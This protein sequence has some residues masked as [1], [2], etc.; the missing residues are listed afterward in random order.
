MARLDFKGKWVLVTGAS[1]GLGR[2]MAMQLAMTEGANLVLMA[3]RADRLEEVKA[4]ILQRT[5]VEVL[6]IPCDLSDVHA[7]EEKLHALLLDMPLYAAVLNAGMTYFGAHLEMGR[8]TLNAL[9][10]LNIKSVVSLTNIL[11]RYFEEH[12]LEGALMLV[13]SMAAQFPTPYQ[14]IYSGT[15]A[16]LLNFGLALGQEL[17]NKRFSITVY[18]PSGIATEMTSDEKFERLKGFLMPVSEAAKEG[19]YA[20]SR[21]KQ[22]WIPGKWNRLGARLSWFIPRRVVLQQTAK[23]YLKSLKAAADIHK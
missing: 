11:T 16:F 12:A 8:D 6:C 2:E 15:K 7:V 10:D 14:A 9:L 21:R 3:R 17:Q 5:S 18:L 13:S 1:A 22:L 23:T 19:I 4:S 20:I